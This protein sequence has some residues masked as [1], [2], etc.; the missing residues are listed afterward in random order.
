MFHGH[1]AGLANGLALAS[2]EPA[3]WLMACIAARVARCISS[4]WMLICSVLRFIRSQP[5][6]AFIS[7]IRLSSSL[8][9]SVGVTM[10]GT[11]KPMLPHMPLRNSMGS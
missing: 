5:S 10:P 9:S 4:P 6:T 3:D 11:A 7:V 1:K 2:A 8:M